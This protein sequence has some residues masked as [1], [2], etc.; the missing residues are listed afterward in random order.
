MKPSSF[1]FIF[2]IASYPSCMVA[3]SFLD[4]EQG[5]LVHSR[6]A[7]TLKSVLLPMFKSLPKNQQGISVNSLALLAA[8]IE[9]G[10]D[11]ETIS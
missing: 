10:I 2:I 5:R 4:G 7:E 11:K 3:R 6:R 1:V 9:D 8:T